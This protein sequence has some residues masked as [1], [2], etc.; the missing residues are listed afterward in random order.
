MPRKGF[1]R[2]PDFLVAFSRCQ[3][4]FSAFDIWVRRAE[5]V[6]KGTRTDLHISGLGFR[7]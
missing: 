1:Y 6:A 4:C 2:V 7:V 5:V 3:L